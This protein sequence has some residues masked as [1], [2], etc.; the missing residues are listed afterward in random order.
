MG[1]RFLWTVLAL[2]GVGLPAALLSA[3]YVGHGAA[4]AT[5]LVALLGPPAIVA[6][7]YDSGGRVLR[8]IVVALALAA[9]STVAYA[10]WQWSLFATEVRNL[11]RMQNHGRILEQ[12]QREHGSFPK[13]LA[14]AA[15]LAPTSLE[16]FGIDEWGN[17]FFYES[18]ED[19]FVLVSFGRDLVT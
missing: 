16:G 4:G 7:A 18:R 3:V 19:S 9:W 17:P 1:K 14:Q 15:S 11:V 2:G 5:S 6:T 12:Y 13:R 10:A 8:A